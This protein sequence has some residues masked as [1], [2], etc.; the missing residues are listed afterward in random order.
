MDTVSLVIGLVSLVGGAAGG[1][2]AG[3]AMKDKSLGAV[4]NS[5]VGILGGGLGGAILHS[6]GYFAKCYDGGID[7]PL[8]VAGG[9]VGGAVLLAVVARIKYAM[10]R[11]VKATE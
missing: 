7:V 5:L 11:P 1:I 3:A 2:L 4:G 9:A 10:R 6:L 8:I